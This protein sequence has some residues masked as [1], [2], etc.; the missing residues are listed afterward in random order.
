MKVS[1]CCSWSAKTL[2]TPDGV[3]CRQPRLMN[4]NST[5][6]INL[7]HRRKLNLSLSLSVKQCQ[8]SCSGSPPVYHDLKMHYKWSV[9]KAIVNIPKGIR[10]KGNLKHTSSNSLRLLGAQ[11]RDLRATSQTLLINNL[12]LLELKW[13]MS[14]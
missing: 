4:V 10:L 14:Q 8:N 11:K 9:K 13:G 6:P 2:S 12:L 5:W 7:C 1:L 3:E